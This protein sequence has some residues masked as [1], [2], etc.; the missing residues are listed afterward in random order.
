MAVWEFGVSMRVGVHA[1]VCRKSTA[2]HVFGLFFCKT[3]KLFFS[4]GSFLLEY[5]I[6][7]KAWKNRRTDGRTDRPI[8][9]G[10]PTAKALFFFNASFL[11]D[12]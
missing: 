4:I 9:N 8:D 10:R 2:T 3:K 7:I 5:D 11:L 6:Y 12:S 1:G